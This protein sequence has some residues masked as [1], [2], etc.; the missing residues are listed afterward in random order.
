MFLPQ[1]QRDT[2]PT[3]VPARLRR[4]PTT[5]I[6]TPS[7]S[8]PDI[9]RLRPG[10]HN[11]Q[12]MRKEGILSARTA[13]TGA[14]CGTTSSVSSRV[15]FDRCG[16]VLDRPS[17]QNFRSSIEEQKPIATG[18]LLVA[19]DDGRRQAAPY[20]GAL[21]LCRICYARSGATR[22]TAPRPW[23]R[24]SFPRGEGPRPRSDRITAGLEPQAPTP[25]LRH[26]ADGK[27]SRG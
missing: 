9:R 24:R 3:R 18:R 2:S 6:P 11:A 4:L 22:E 15:A 19:C 1:D 14:V 23:A 7:E 21:L 27:C 20:D 16:R 25:W 17:L 8:Q 12:S 13:D 26:V 5:A 10:T